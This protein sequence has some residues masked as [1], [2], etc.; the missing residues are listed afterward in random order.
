MVRPS[1][2]KK[3]ILLVESE[4]K[5]NLVK[6]MEAEQRTKLLLKLWRSGLMTKDVKKTLK[7]QM[8]SKR[9]CSKKNLKLQEVLMK[10]C[11][12]DSRMDDSKLRK[13]RKKIKQK[14]LTMYGENQEKLTKTLSKMRKKVVR[15]KKKVQKKNKKKIEKYKREKEEEEM[16]ELSILP[17]D[18]KEF[19][20]LRIFRNVQ[21]PPEEPKPPVIT[22]KT[23]L[24]ED[25]LGVLKKGPSFTIR[26]VMDKE[27][28]MAEVEKGLAK[29][30]YSD[31]GKDVEDKEEEVDS[32]EAKRIDDLVAWI[33][34]KSAMIYDFES[35]TMDFG[36][37][38]ATN[39]K[40]NKRI[41][42]PKASSSLLE[43]SM[44][45]RRKAA[46]KIYEECI[47]LLDDGA[48]TIGMDN[49]TAGEKRGLKSLKK[50]VKDGNLL[51][52]QTDKSGRF[53]VMDKEQYRMA[54]HEHTAKDRKI[55]AEEHGEIQRAVNGHMRWWGGIW[56][57]GSNWGQEERSLNN[58]LNYGLVCCPLT[59]LVK[60]HKVWDV[61]PKVRPVMGGNVGGNAGMSEF[62]SLVLEP[63]ADEMEG[64][65]EINATNG[66]LKDIEDVNSKLD[67]E[68][69]KRSE[70][71]QRNEQAE[72]GG[73]EGWVTDEPLPDGWRDSEQAEQVYP[74]GW[75]G[76]DHLPD[77]WKN[78]KQAEPV[79]P[80]GWIADDQLPDGWKAKMNPSDGMSSA[81]DPNHGDEKAKEKLE[82]PQNSTIKKDDIRLYMT[83]NR[84]DGGA[85]TIRAKDNTREIPKIDKMKIIR[86]KMTQS[87][88][89]KENQEIKNAILVQKKSLPKTW[90]GEK[91]SY[92]RD[93]DNKLV[94]DEVEMVIVGADVEALYP[95]LTDL[96]VAQICYDAIMNSKI[97]FE[98]VNYRKARMY[99][100]SSLSKSEQ[101]ISKL[102]RVL[103]RRTAK[104][105]VR[106]GCTADPEKEENW[107]F[108]AAT[109][110]ELDE[111]MIVATVVQIGVLAQMNTHVYTFDGEMFLQKAGGPIGLRS[112]CAVARITMS[113]WDARWQRMMAENNVN[114]MGADRYMD[115]I[116]SFLKSL[117]Q[118]WRWLEGNLCFT[119]TWRKE[120]ELENLSPTRRTANRLLE[121]MN[122]ILNFLNF[123][124]EVGEDFGDNKLPSLDTTIWV[125]HDRILFQFFS[126][127]MATNLVV[128]AKS[129]LSEDMKL[130]TLAEEVCRRLRNTS[131][132]LDH[133]CRLETLENLCTKMST[134]GHTT[135]FMRRAMERGIRSYNTKLNRSKLH[136]SNPRYQPLYVGWQ[137]K[138][139]ERKKSKI[140]KKNSWFQAGSE[141]R[142]GDEGK[143][144]PSGRSRSKKMNRNPEIKDESV[145]F[146]PS[147]RGGILT[148]R[149]RER[150]VELSK[151]TGFGIKFQEAGGTQM[152]RLFNTNLGGGLHCGRK[153]CPPCDS[154]EE[155]KRGDCKAQNLVYES[156]CTLC[157]PSSRQEDAKAGRSGVYFGET[158]RTIH[159]RALEHLKDATSFSQK[160]HQVKH[161]MNSHQDEDAQPAFRIKTVRRYRDCLSRQIGEALRIYYS[162][163]QL[164]NSKSEYVQNCISRVV[165]NE[166]SWERRERER[167]EEEEEEKEKLQLEKFREEKSRRQAT[168]D[169]SSLQEETDPNSGVEDITTVLGG[170]IK[171]RRDMAQMDGKMTSKKAR[172]ELP[173]HQND[174]EA[175]DDIPEGRKNPEEGAVH[176]PCHD[177]SSEDLDAPAHPI[178]HPEGG[179]HAIARIGMLPDGVGPKKPKTGEIQQ[180]GPA[181]VTNLGV[182]R[183]VRGKEESQEKGRKSTTKKP[184][185]GSIMNLAWFSYWWKRMEREAAK[186]NEEK[187]RKH[188]GFRLRE[189]FVRLSDSE[190]TSE[191]V[192]VK[193]SSKCDDV[194]NGRHPET[195]EFKERHPTTVSKQGQGYQLRGKKRYIPGEYES[196]S[197]RRGEIGKGTNQTIN[198]VRELITEGGNFKEAASI[199]ITSESEVCLK[200]SGSMEVI[201]RH[202]AMEGDELIVTDQYKPGGDVT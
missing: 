158:S 100:A 198:P 109:P 86:D 62:I 97:K 148:R 143:N 79:G 31:I 135:K 144:Q 88:K 17:E 82:V 34:E 128:Q 104:G 93:V 28:F 54:G 51:I 14:L 201:C 74:E 130:S 177:A 40:R 131:R 176:A 25:E 56:N 125:E 160:S 136:K 27:A 77:G 150:E 98:N 195:D 164:L 35:K 7:K 171:K 163:D 30:M 22:T 29:K 18:L 122:S 142:D 12:K 183:G 70:A 44:E 114:L 90:R 140:L 173:V 147:T 50:K 159:E 11:I 73:P 103:P 189:H 180:P 185:Q 134:S 115:D 71:L 49:L 155:G 48:E 26:N 15:L 78:N 199:E 152:I 137:W 21:I 196:P 129:A 3:T 118:G 92:A 45:I 191:S 112:T 102:Y 61:V 42:L 69:I 156:V 132:R 116:R 65:I 80:E 81:D 154:S 146:V 8:N 167:K 36:R 193:I 170:W 60:D 6:T 53:C 110:T 188:D 169:P 72:P 141:D 113:T 108:P 58:I 149:L 91:L 186:E 192:P 99:I 20:D 165:A 89:R 174:G 126:K 2:A 33:D 107:I 24:T 153:P 179:P 178:S 68:D 95:S 84:N 41:K 52:C 121:S 66:L 151:T 124:Q 200:I 43:A 190:Y 168:L 59:L 94:Q 101:R 47:K 166:E 133:S 202:K 4:L 16:R 138:R 96:E 145:I 23:I 64:S 39:W 10:G 194:V 85:H 38:K 46:G 19:S 139:N 106:P 117:R 57:L 119:E 161:W 67:E 63:V 197:K 175:I 172:V 181:S 1:E 111:R 55:S 87:R 120:D 37:S 13:E 162:K 105:G 5:E 182:V 76:S 157:N 75:I 9:R 127:P 32:A 184:K 187:L 83:V 123:T